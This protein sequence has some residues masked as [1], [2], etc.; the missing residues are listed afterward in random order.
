MLRCVCVCEYLYVLVRRWVV[1]WVYTAMY[2]HTYMYMHAAIYTLTYIY[3]HAYTCYIHYTQK[4]HYTH[5]HDVCITYT[6]TSY[7]LN[8]FSMHTY[9]PAYLALMDVCLYKWMYASINGCRV[10]LLYNMED[11]DR[12]ASYTHTC[13]HVL[14]YK[15]HI[16]DM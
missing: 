6:R 11:F 2:T 5:T 16:R 4:H 15:G 8:S 7:T 14:T 9:V 13:I 3:I 1:G 12:Y 10:Y